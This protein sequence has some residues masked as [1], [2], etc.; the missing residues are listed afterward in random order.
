MNWNGINLRWAYT[1]LLLSLSRQTRCVHS[2]YDILHDAFIRY[3]L[4][5]QRITIEQPN[6][7]LRRVAHSV[8]IDH[9]RDASRYMPLYDDE[10]ACLTHG[11]VNE[12]FAPS[13]E[14]LADLQQRL[15][16]LQRI[17]DCLPPRC[18]EVFWL[19]RI[20]G[21]RQAHIASLLNI[22]LSMVERHLM[23]ALLDLRAARETLCP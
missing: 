16:A 12:E 19:A 3:M 17:L 23:R 13:A 4:A 22:S 15:E 18:R 7:Y 10:G 1:D 5:S 14:H 2:A 21:H 20:E 11:N 9:Y 8:L 6:A